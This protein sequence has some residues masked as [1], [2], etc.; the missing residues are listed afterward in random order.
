MTKLTSHPIPD[1]RNQIRGWV[2]AIV[3]VTLAAAIAVMMR[4][5]PD[6]T[7]QHEAVSSEGR[8]VSRAARWKAPATPSSSITGVVR[9]A[10]GLAI[11]GAVVC[12]VSVRSSAPDRCVD[13]GE[14]G[15]FWLDGLAADGYVLHA[16]A[17]GFAPTV[18]QGGRPI[19]LIDGEPK[20]EADI[21]LAKG[22]EKLAGVVVDATG[23]VVPRATVRAARLPGATNTIDV[24]ADEEG[25]FALSTSAGSVAVSAKSEGYCRSRLVYTTAP[26][27]HVVL[28]LIPESTIAGTVV[29][30][31]GEPVPGMR[32]SAEAVGG[33]SMPSAPSAPTNEQG[34]FVVTGL[35]T[36]AYA[37]SAEGDHRRGFEPGP[38]DLD[39]AD[40]LQGALI[41]VDSVPTVAGRVVMADDTPCASGKVM[42][43][44]SD[45]A[46]PLP[47]MKAAI[48]L[49]GNVQFSAVPPGSYSL[50]VLCRNQ[51]LRDGPRVVTVGP[52][53]VSGLLWKVGLGLALEVRVLDELDEPVPHAPF[54]V[55][56][57]QPAGAPPGYMMAS[58]N[59]QGTY[60]Y[61]TT[62]VPG[63]YVVKTNGTLHGE[64]V[65]VYLEEGQGKATATL[66]V[67]GSSYVTVNV[68]TTHGEPVNDVV[69]LAHPTAEPGA[70]GD[71]AAAPQRPGAVGA[72]IG[73]GQYRVGPIA[74]GRYEISV[75]DS[76]NPSAAQSS[77]TSVL[78]SS[79]SEAEATITL[80]R[81]GSISG[82]VRNSA[83]ELLADVWVSVSRAEAPTDSRADLIAAMNRSRG[84]SPAHRVLTD[85]DGRFRLDSLESGASFDVRAETLKDGVAI[86]R[87]VRSGEV[88][89]LSFSAVGTLRGAAFL[90][91]GR[92]AAESSV[93]VT[94]IETG[95]SRVAP[96][97]PDGSWE[98][99]GVG[100]GRIRV[101]AADDQG[102]FAN[103][104]LE[105]RPNQTL[106]QIRL[107]LRP[108]QPEA[109]D[110]RP[111][112]A[113][114]HNPTL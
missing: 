4:R 25:R 10:A 39:V 91:D 57:P 50:D 103:N 73:D 67:A 34:E 108:S 83:G 106:D 54:M 51:V 12:A 69:V 100:A 85:A 70:G 109:P 87:G 46:A 26:S 84:T 113:V 97:S 43:T 110:G 65:V 86:A 13:T 71:S 62:L 28:V 35:S 5:T 23:G 24:I 56:I 105:L 9:D 76:V 89:A 18:A 49:N 48:D 2:A 74:A 94:Q 38:F 102:Y 75:D 63:R 29:T 45:D 40:R 72:A 14:Q 20:R 1:D 82:I 64:P 42:M 99:S 15:V 101:V 11:G 52:D 98:L 80:D 114:A 88:V 53:D 7:P 66:R 104:D 22:G 37:L 33:L 32:V 92:P 81:G 16:S 44:P 93:Q 77:R 58:T 111:E 79:R 112:P 36:G 17:L 30:R 31:D 59:A 19:V 60:E 107:T 47:S 55:Q 8:A 27:E 95:W 21:T 68:R 41:V 3:L 61:A 6:T 78:V 90:E 96:V